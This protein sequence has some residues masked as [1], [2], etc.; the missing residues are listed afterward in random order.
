MY[1]L[2]AHTL[3]YSSSG[4]ADPEKLQKNLAGCR[5]C[6]AGN[7]ISIFH[8][9]LCTRVEAGSHPYIYHTHPV[10]LHVCGR[11]LGTAMSLTSPWARRQRIW[12][13][14]SLHSP[15]H[16]L[17]VRCT[18]Q[19][20]CALHRSLL[21]TQN[22]KW[23]HR[24]KCKGKGIPWSYGKEEYIAKNVTKMSV[25]R[26]IKGSFTKLSSGTRLL[27]LF[28]HQT[29]NCS[30]CK[31]WNDKIRKQTVWWFWMAFLTW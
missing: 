19:T 29:E 14:R 17:S 6:R 22:A 24:T 13:H 23:T 4:G 30:L 11:R 12:Q 27:L 26:N 18:L 25:S 21:A 2:A 1:K 20:L 7:Q 8:D 10:A 31:L 28:R 16:H 5:L 15:E 9:T 3:L